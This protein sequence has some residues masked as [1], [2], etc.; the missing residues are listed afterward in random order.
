MKSGLRELSD[1][2]QRQTFPSLAIVSILCDVFYVTG[3][4]LHTVAHFS[5]TEPHALSLETKVIIG[6]DLSQF[7]KYSS[8]PTIEMVARYRI[9]S[10]E[11]EFE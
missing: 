10:P 2:G 9:G 3:I 6:T 8:L 7:L 11:S 1:C 5:L 4:N